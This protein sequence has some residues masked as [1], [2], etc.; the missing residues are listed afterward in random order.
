[1]EGHTRDL[2]RSNSGFKWHMKQ[3]RNQ[4][5]L[6]FPSMRCLSQDGHPIKWLWPPWLLT[7]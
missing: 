5:I 4:L 7:E 6:E 2:P 3:G 1:M